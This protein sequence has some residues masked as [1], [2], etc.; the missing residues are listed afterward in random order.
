ME[1]KNIL[2]TGGAGFIAS[3]IVDRLVN[4]N[5]LTIYDNYKRNAIKFTNLENN[6]NVKVVSGDIL[7][8][9]QLSNTKFDLIIH[10]AAIAGIYSVSK[11]PA[12]TLKVNLIGTYN[13]LEYA[14]KNNIN[15]VID[16]S[17]SEI[18][19]SFAYK[20]TE[21]QLSTV[22]PVSESR[23]VYSVGK[24]AGEH[25]VHA[26]SKE[27]GL[28]VTTVRPF[29]V[30]GPRQV[31]EGAIQ[32][33]V[34]NALSGKDIVVYNDGTQV[35]AW[36]YIS[37]F[38]DA[39]EGILDSPEVSV[40]ETFNIGNP[41]ASTTVLGLAEKIVDLT[42]SKSKIVFK[43]HPGQ[44]IEVRIPNIDKADAY[45]G[46]SPKVGLEEGLRASID[47]YLGESK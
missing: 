23:W 46:Y 16:F 19:G 43:K 14:L 36:C 42:G 2:I 22:G 1:N 18:Y 45:L 4:N 27:Y 20:A 9:G 13:V 17:T 32:Q 3:H 21:D 11:E 40:N 24:L 37:D 8:M 34:I 28:E 25:L 26:Y 41:K 44:E 5:R 29:N 47:W 10:C 12:T 31:G 6:K 33:M 38:V 39:I 7:D 15:R 30:Y 35:R